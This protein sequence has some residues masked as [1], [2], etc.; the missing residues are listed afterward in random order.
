[1]HL[2]GVDN[3]HGT[4]YRELSTVGAGFFSQ[5]LPAPILE[6]HAL[7]A[8]MFDLRACTSFTSPQV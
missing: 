6:E 3:P 8:Y 4:E 5:W 2:T 7:R 1:M